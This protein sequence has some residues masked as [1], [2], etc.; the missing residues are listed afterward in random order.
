VILNVTI[1][2]LVT[3]QRLC[4]LWLSQRN[5]RRL[6]E[7][8]ASEHA[9]SHYPLIIAVHA[10]W[11]A[12]LWWLAP[13]RAIQSYWLALF[14]CLEAAR[15]WVLA[16][17]GS[18]WTTRIIVLPRAKLVLRGPY[19]FVNH[20]NYWVVVGEIAVFPLV[21]G[22]WKVAVVFTILNAAVLALR[23]REEDRA[24]GRNPGALQS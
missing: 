2:A 8:G 17:L 6:L 5:T 23:I 10:L 13:M 3:L 4:E 16:S 15:V 20:P 11:L 21:F 1:L 9:R 24:L 22:L 19:R 7:Q 12:T 18:R 14:V